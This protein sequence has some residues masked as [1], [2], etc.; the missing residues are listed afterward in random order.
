MDH[1]APFQCI[2]RGPLL[3][4]PNAQ[5][6]SAAI[7]ARAVSSLKA[8]DPFGEGTM[9]QLLPFPFS[10][11]VW[12]YLPGTT[13]LPAAHTSLLAS[14]ATLARYPSPRIG[15]PPLAVHEVPF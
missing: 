15:A 3:S 2:A 5:T 1:A 14:A 12:L 9:P 4:L 8:L 10:M 6:S 13:R 11:R 7:G